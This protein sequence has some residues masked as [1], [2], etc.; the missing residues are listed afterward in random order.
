V[1]VLESWRLRLK[2]MFDGNVKLLYRFLVIKNVDQ[3][4]VRCP[5]SR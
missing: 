1:G 5:Y 3:I 2:S 4:T